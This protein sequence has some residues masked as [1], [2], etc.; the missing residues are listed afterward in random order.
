MRSLLLILASSLACSTS[1]AAAADGGPPVIVE[2]FTSQGCSSCPPGEAL[3][4]R[5]A[6]DG[7]SGGRRVV[8]LAFHVD[9]WDD[10]GWADPSASPTWTDRQQRYAA[11]RGD[12]RIYTPQLVVA[13][14]AHVVGS[15]VGAVEGA[16]ARAPAQRP[17]DASATR[18][19]S[20]LHVRATAP[21]D[22]DVW[23]AVWEDGVTTAI[24]RGE[25]AGRRLREDRV[26]RR[27]LRVATANTRGR[28]DVALDPRW[29]RVGAVAFAQRPDT[30]AIVGATLLSP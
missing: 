16:I 5:L 15:Q 10:L 1:D 23:L 6:A 18:D 9:Y 21:A 30:L 28:I 26:V 14:G 24:P 11:A 13:G 25:N 17:V 8:P 12:R 3:L 2:L 7:A 27:L 20:G 22:A 29:G 4:S 19:G